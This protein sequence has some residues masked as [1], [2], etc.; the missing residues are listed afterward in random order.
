[1]FRVSQRQSPIFVAWREATIN[2]IKKYRV[3][4]EDFKRQIQNGNVF[5][6]EKHYAKEDIEF[7]KTGKKAL[8]FGAV[9]TL[10]LPTKSHSTSQTE[11]RVLLLHKKVDLEVKETCCYRNFKELCSRTEKLKLKSWQLQLQEGSISLICY[12]KEYAIP[13]YEINID[14]N[15]RCTCSVFGWLL[16]NEH[17]IYEDVDRNMKNITVSNLLCKVET[18]QRAEKCH[19]LCA[20]KEQCSHCTAVEK[21]F[22]NKTLKNSRHINTPA[23]PNA[24]VTVT[25]PNRLKLALQEQILKCSQLENRISK[26]E[27]EIKLSGIQIHPDLSH[28]MKDIMSKH[29]GGISPFMKLFWEQQQRYFSGD[30]HSVRYHPM[31]MRFCITS[32]SCK[33]ASAY[34]ELRNSGVLTLPSRRTLRDYRNA[35]KPTV[36]FN[37]AV[38]MELI[39]ETQGLQGIQRYVALGF[40]EMKI[41]PIFWKAVCILEVTCM[42]PVIV[43]VSDVA[44]ANQK[45][46]KMHT[47]LD[48]DADKPVTYRT[49][50]F[51]APNRFLLFFA[52]APHLLKA[53]RNCL[54]QSGNGRSCLMLHN[55]KHVIWQHLCQIVKDDMGNA[56]KICPKLT[57]EHIELSSYS[58]MNVRLAAQALSGTT[59]IILKEYYGDDTSGTAE[60]CHRMDRFFDM[61]N[62][63]STKEHLLKRKESMK[64]FVSCDDERFSWLKNDFLGYL[65]DWKESIDVQDAT[66]SAKE[67]MFISRPTHEGL[68]ITTYSVIEA[69]KYLL[70]NGFDF[71]LTNRFNQD[72]VEEYFGRQRSLGRRS[73]N[74]TI[75][76]FG[77]QDNTIRMQ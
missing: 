38:I 75:W 18:M 50:N 41:M 14:E 71:V 13:K 5:T 20:Q 30:S 64:P 73:D 11:R 77:Y 29:E 26:M 4:D 44:A 42:L 32:T 25:H 23:K 16:P 74:P 61:L 37:P 35:I 70:N 69:T 33:S 72:M 49:V 45:F 65:K 56:L 34:D 15:L 55:G 1:M 9:P 51:Y 68:Q 39:K 46:F 53:A 47:Q 10:N 19:V 62:I 54:Y 31:I 17:E 36:G 58:I 43:T 67:K 48:G 8:R 22:T 2:V 66:A 3:V 40:D 24:P 27:T 7:T 76:Q 12:L 52:D 28:D 57:K 63:R 59:A 6:C 21:K 60:F